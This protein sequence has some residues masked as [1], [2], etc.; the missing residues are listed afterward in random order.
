MADAGGFRREARTGTRHGDEPESKLSSCRIT[1][2]AALRLRG[3]SQSRFSNAP[4]HPFRSQHGGVAFLQLHR[5]RGRGTHFNRAGALLRG[6]GQGRGGRGAV[7]VVS[8][9]TRAWPG[10]GAAPTEPGLRGTGLSSGWGGVGGQ[11]GPR[12]KACD[13]CQAMLKHLVELMPVTLEKAGHAFLP[14]RHSG[15]SGDVRDTYSH[16]MRW[17]TPAGY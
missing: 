3:A 1:S 12:W 7:G 6:D 5:W 9:G 14:T 2:G 17:M 15:R 13:H 8:C 10:K 11:P 4:P 16:P